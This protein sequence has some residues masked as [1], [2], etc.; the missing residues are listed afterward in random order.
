MISKW[1][2]SYAETAAEMLNVTDKTILEWSNGEV[3]IISEDD[4]LPHSLEDLNI[5]GSMESLEMGHI[6]LPIPIINVQ[7]LCGRRPILAGIIGMTQNETEQIVHYAKYVNINK[8]S[9]DFKH[10]VGYKEYC[11][12][13]NKNDYRT[14][15]EAIELL[16]DKT[17]ELRPKIILHNLPVIPLS[18]RYVKEGEIFHPMYINYMYE[19]IIN[20]ISRLSKLTE[21]TAPEIILLNESR[22]L[23]EY[24]DQLINNGAYGILVIMGNGCPAESLSELYESI[25]KDVKRTNYIIP[26]DYEIEKELNA[27]ITEYQEYEKEC[28]KNENIDLREEER[29]KDEILDCIINKLD[30]F[31]HTIMETYFKGYEERPF[32]TVARYS[33]LGIISNLDCQRSIEEQL[34]KGIGK[35]FENFAKKRVKFLKGE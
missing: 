34:C 20:R 26:D 27:L 5:F 13:Q 12:L 18:M 29:R 10:I 8:N 14:G 3:N 17:S 24:V 11:Q 1:R 25:T 33:I 21:L 4:V 31:L 30:P 15:A 16:I 2:N 19:R 23:Q 28:E 6:E 9:S 7:Y 22:M 35:T 32:L